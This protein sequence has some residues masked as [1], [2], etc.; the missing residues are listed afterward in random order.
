MRYELYQNLFRMVFRK[1]SYEMAVRTLGRRWLSGR[2]IAYT[3]H[4]TGDT[5]SS[6]GG[7]H[8][9]KSAAVRQNY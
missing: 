1:T 9:D 4:L 5:G 6:A 7:V 3:S 8:D 2:K